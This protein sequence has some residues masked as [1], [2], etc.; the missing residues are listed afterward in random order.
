VVTH[1]RQVLFEP[2]QTESLLKDAE[3]GQCGFLYTGDPKYLAPYNLAIGQIEPN[4][5]KLTQLTAASLEGL[6]SVTLNPPHAPVFAGHAVRESPSRGVCSMQESPGPKVSG[7]L[8]I[9]RAF[10]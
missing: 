10:E 7:M 1:T 8:L 5:E 6:V 4:I 2:A 9:K 3:T